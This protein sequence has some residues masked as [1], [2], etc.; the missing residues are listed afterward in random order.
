MSPLKLSLGWRTCSWFD[1]EG[2]V[3]MQPMAAVEE[4]VLHCLG[5]TNLDFSNSSS[6]RIDVLGIASEESEIEMYYMLNWITDGSKGHGVIMCMMEKKKE[7][8]DVFDCYKSWNYI[9][10][11]H[12]TGFQTT[13]GSK[14]RIVH[15]D[16]DIEDQLVT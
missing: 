12:L 14:W 1:I 5:W 11:Q 6:M 13:T 10:G 7:K 16:K 8:K 4:K 9:I 3:K 2:P 15:Y